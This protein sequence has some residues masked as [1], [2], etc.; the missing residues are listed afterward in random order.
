MSMASIAYFRFRFT[1]TSP[2]NGCVTTSS[3]IF[4]DRATFESVLSSWNRQD[5]IY[6]QTAIDAAANT[7][8]EK[9]ACF[10]SVFGA[11]DSV[12]AWSR[13]GHCYVVPSE[14][15]IENAKAFRLSID[16]VT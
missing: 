5:W 9:V 14:K 3:A 2:H 15:A 1:S 16:T 4:Q 6:E 11:I 7:V 10:E 12:Q 8:P 13:S